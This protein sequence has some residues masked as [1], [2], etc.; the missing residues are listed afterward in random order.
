MGTSL[1]TKS[2]TDLD[3]VKTETPKKRGRARV[4]CARTQLAPTSCVSAA[5]FRLNVRGSART[6]AQA[7]AAAVAAADVA[8]GSGKRRV[9]SSIPPL[10]ALEPKLPLR[11][12]GT[13]GRLDFTAEKEKIQ[14]KRRDKNRKR[15]KM[16]PD[17]VTAVRVSAVVTL[18]PSFSP[19]LF[20]QR[21]NDKHLYLSMLL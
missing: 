11:Q 17:N 19:H 4:A 15:G 14:R 10:W 9:C 6:G 16:A 18:Y 13:S 3:I 7:A 5:G 20:H 12:L 2:F 21:S 1:H 8:Q